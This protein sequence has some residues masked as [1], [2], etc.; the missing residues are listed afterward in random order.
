VA[1]TASQAGVYAKGLNAT[2]SECC[3]SHLHRRVGLEYMKHLNYRHQ[4]IIQNKAYNILFEQ[5]REIYE[6]CGILCEK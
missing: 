6:I 3:L 1:Q 4:W 2:V 5:K